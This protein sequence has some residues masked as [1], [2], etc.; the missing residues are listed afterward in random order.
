MTT[1]VL[2]QGDQDPVNKRVLSTP[3]VTIA[4]DQSEK[5]RGHHHRYGQHVTLKP[6]TVEIGVDNKSSAVIIWTEGE[7]DHHRKQDITMKAKTI[8][9]GCD[10]YSSGRWLH[11][12][13][14]IG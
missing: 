4:F 10:E 2:P 7:S 13:N 8:Q 1:I 9:I 5:S 3:W 11:V 14:N 12:V 6:D